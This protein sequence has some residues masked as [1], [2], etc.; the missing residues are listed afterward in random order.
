MNYNNG[1]FIK[2]QIITVLAG[3]F[4]QL[5]KKGVYNSFNHTILFTFNIMINQ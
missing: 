2:C 3:C 5:N 1:M 4:I